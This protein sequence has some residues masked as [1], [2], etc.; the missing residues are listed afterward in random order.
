MAKFMQCKDAQDY[1]CATYPKFLVE[2][3][4]DP[5][6]GIGVTDKLHPRENP[7]TGEKYIPMAQLPHHDSWGTNTLGKVLMELRVTLLYYRKRI[8]E[9]EREAPEVSSQQT[10]TSSGGSGLV[11]PAG[12]V[13]ADSVPVI[14][15]E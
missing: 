10:S 12:G 5:F 15:L 3:T 13:Q 7:E 2:A 14:T 4:A 1:L 9:G 8:N 11:G 6:W